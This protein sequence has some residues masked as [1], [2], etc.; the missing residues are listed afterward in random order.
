M[1]TSQG[2]LYTTLGLNP[3]D[4][5]DELRT[6]IMGRDAQLENQGHPPQHPQRQQLQ[7]GYAV[8]GDQP[9][10]QIYDHAI[11]SGRHLAWHEI[12]HLAN[13]GRLPEIPFQQSPQSAA[14][15]PGQTPFSTAFQ[16]P[17]PPIPGMPTGGG[18]GHPLA[19]NM[20]QPV[21][22]GAADRPSAGMRLLMLIVDG[23]IFS[24][25]AGLV[26]LAFF[27]SETLMTVL[28][29]LGFLLYFLGLEFRTGATPA[30]H[31][32]GYEVR[33]LATGGRPSLLQSGKRQLWRLVSVVPG[34]GNLISFIAMIYLGS[35]I[36]SGTGYLGRHDQWAGTEVTRKR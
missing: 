35:T 25:A 21:P 1:N 3:G 10:R 14:G 32:F 20:A 33:D 16:Q 7:V 17:A 23:F 2:E 4:G 36:N 31:L 18:P 9:R 13:F 11:A 29:V 34:L 22:V 28:W 15:Q 5:T 8:L 6:L 12:E 26:G 27:W 30:K 19:R 24:A